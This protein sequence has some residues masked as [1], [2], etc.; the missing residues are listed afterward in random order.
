MYLW[1]WFERQC[2]HENSD[3]LNFHWWALNSNRLQGKSGNLGME[4]R[5]QEAG[6]WTCIFD[7]HVFLMGM[8]WPFQLCLCISTSWLLRGKVTL[9][10]LLL[11]MMLAKANTDTPLQKLWAEGKPFK[12]VFVH[13]T[14][15]ESLTNI[16]SS[17]TWTYITVIFSLF[18]Y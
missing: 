6:H 10:T 18:S 13:K 12:L 2:N 14:R 5:T 16:H 11:I 3:L 15:K 8:F 4:V 9:L 7:G 1:Q 17:N